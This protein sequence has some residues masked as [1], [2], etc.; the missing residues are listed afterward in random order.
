VRANDADL[1]SL[2]RFERAALRVGARVNESPRAKRASRRFNE[3]VTGRWMTLVSERRMTL[4]GLD[5][6]RALRPDRGV[7]LAANHRSF[8]DMYMVLTHLHKRVDWCERAYFPVR[9][10]FWYDHPLGLLTNAMVSGMSMYPPI[11]REVEKRS[12]TRL[13][14]DFL[15]AE[16]QRPGTLVGIH[17]EG[18]R[19]KGDDPYDLLPAEQGFGRVVLSARPIVLPVFIN[20]M[21]NDFIHECRSTLDGSG[22]P[23]IMSFGPPVEFGEMLEADPQRLRAQVAIGRRVLEEIAALGSIERA[24]R[25]TLATSA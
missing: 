16:L 15:A 6:V 7:L 10:T 18:T 20:G 24:E 13:G 5:H 1:S 21:A 3:L 22:M 8:F 23:I 19:N 17:P 12:V 2:T 11:Y 9:S 25:E 14:L 4:L